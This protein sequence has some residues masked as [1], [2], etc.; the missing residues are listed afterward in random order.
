MRISL[1]VDLAGKSAGKFER[2]EVGHL[3][4]VGRLRRGT[5]RSL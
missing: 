3:E 1:S 4:P 5:Q 2:S